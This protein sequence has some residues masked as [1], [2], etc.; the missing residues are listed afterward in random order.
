MACLDR[1]YVYVQV[2][3]TVAWSLG[4]VGKLSDAVRAL[5][6]RC[7]HPVMG[8]VL[9]SHLQRQAAIKGVVLVCLGVRWLPEVR[10]GSL[11]GFRSQH[12]PTCLPLLSRR[13]GD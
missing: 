13:A 4:N 9:G 12:T 3:V 6:R 1:S 8:D 5:L 2:D 10:T 11:N 7:G